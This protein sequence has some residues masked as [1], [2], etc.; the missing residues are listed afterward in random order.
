VRIRHFTRT[1]VETSANHDNKLITTS[2]NSALCHISGNNLQEHKDAEVPA[3]SFRPRRHIL[4]ESFHHTLRSLTG[5][6][7]S[8]KL[9]M[10]LR[11]NRRLWL[12]PAE[13]LALLTIFEEQDRRAAHYMCHH[14]QFTLFIHVDLGDSDIVTD[15]CGDFIQQWGQLLAWTTHSAQKSTITSLSE[16]I[17]SLRKVSLVTSIT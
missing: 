4:L 17:T 10:N 2:P 5:T 9:R 11:S 6:R 12:Q 13:L 3:G 15:F 7:K 8:L 1:S 16:S 14:A